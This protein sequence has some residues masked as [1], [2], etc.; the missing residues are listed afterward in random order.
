MAVLYIR[1]RQLSCMA[2]LWWNVCHRLSA[3]ILLGELIS[4]VTSLTP[5]PTTPHPEQVQNHEILLLK[6][7]KIS[8][9]LSMPICPLLLAL[10]LQMS[11]ARVACSYKLV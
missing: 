10:L 11:A 3:W 6:R 7:T 2:L 4:V 8:Y 5:V 9:F 1:P